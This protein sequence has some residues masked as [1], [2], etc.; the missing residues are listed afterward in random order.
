MSGESK[1]REKPVRLPDSR[2]LDWDT[3]IP[4][5]LADI[6]PLST[7]SARSHRYAMLLQQLFGL[8]PEFIDYTAGIERFL[9]SRQRDRILR[10]R[11]DNL[12]GNLII[13]FEAQIPQ[14]L[15]E[16]HEQLRR[17]TAILWS[18]EAVDER[19]PYLGHATDG[20]RFVTYSPAIGD[21]SLSD[22]TPDD[23]HMSIVEE[24]DWTRLEPHEIFYWLDRHIRRNESLHPTSENIV[25]DFGTTSHAYQSVTQALSALWQEI[26]SASC[27]SVI[28][29]NWEK[30]LRIVYGSEIT[31]HG[32]FIRHTYLATVAKLM[33]WMRVADSEGPL[34]DNAIVQILDGGFFSDRGIDNYLEEDL[35]SWIVRAGAASAGLS[36][37][38]WLF[39]LLQNYNLRELSEDILKSLYQELVDPET[40]HD[41]GEYYTPDWLAHRIV[42]KTLDTN[43]DASVFD[44]ACGSGTFL[45]L[46]IREKRAR[47]PDSASTLTNIVG[48]VYGADVH[49]LAVVIAK[50]NYILALG[51][52]LQRRKG[53][54]SIPVYLS[55][56]VQLPQRTVPR[57]ARIPELAAQTWMQGD[58]YEVHLDGQQVYFTEALMADPA[59]YDKA[60]D[61]IRVFA[62]EYAHK[63][64][65][66]ELFHSFLQ[67]SH[68][69]LVLDT[70][71]VK[72]LYFAATTLKGLVEQDRD[73]IWAFV[74]KNIYKPL[75]LQKRFDF[76]IGNPPW[77]AYRF[78]EPNYQAF[79]KEQITKQY[80]LLSARSGQLITHLELGTLFLV[81]AAHLYLKPGGTVAFVLPRSVFS[82]DQHDALRRRTFTFPR[83]MAHQ[84]F[85][86]EVWDCD[87]VTPVFSVPSCV[88]FGEKGDVG[89]MTYPI[90]GEVL[91]GKLPRRNASLVAAEEALSVADIELSLHVRGRRSYWAEGDPPKRQVESPYKKRFMQGATI[92]PRSMWFVQTKP[93]PV[94]FDPQLPPLETSTQ[95]MHDAKKPYRDVRLEGSVESRFLYATMLAGD[96][97]PFGC[98]RH[99]L[100]VLP[101]EPVGDQYELIDARKAREKGC[102]GLAQWL[103]QVETEWQQRR[104]EKSRNAS[105]LDWLDYRH[106]LTAQN[107][108]CRYRTVYNTSGTFLAAAVVERGAIACDELQTGGFL[109]DAKTYA[110][111][112]DSGEEAFYLASILN[113]PVI[114]ELVKPMQSRGLWG[115]RDIHKKVLELPFPQFDAQDDVHRALSVLGETCS[116]KVAAWLAGGGAGASRSIGKLRANTRAMLADDMA[117]IDELVRRL[118][119]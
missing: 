82:A 92:V 56:T 28:Y 73:T 86:R 118:I 111:E 6:E 89:K 29:D 72:A 27:F 10:G 77:L 61:A 4:Q 23:V 22:I 68:S 106:K 1:L 102:F 14:K 8:E 98:L 84:L 11:A 49:P 40:R 17:Y 51:D 70:Q 97:I 109:V 26:G 36:V 85:W 119:S 83:N 54:V 7:E 94:G 31:D 35:F 37:T 43:A 116:T 15:S 66:E 113:A 117:A 39:S 107:P 21:A 12:Y 19:T 93:S 48:S 32:L 55:N 65:D 114:D 34:A 99:R 75:F 50:T 74:L 90:R 3:I 101:I 52:L 45:Y 30:Y 95:A 42:N 59:L 112:L 80:R 33:S 60:I 44:P 115:P 67:T 108:L 62:D 47:L 71:T 9:K 63:A 87:E 57:F 20:V 46:T 88:V 25:R 81:R 96:L 91:R 24:V 104:S 76:V 100:V 16:A 58:L 13:E 78:A 69:D 18:N 38:R 103:A 64:V 79:L 105:A 5:Y 110:C 53:R 41:L 2:Q